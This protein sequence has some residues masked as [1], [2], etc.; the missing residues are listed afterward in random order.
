[1]NDKIVREH[2]FEHSINKVWDAI[3]KAEEISEWF[4]TADFKAE[5]GYKYTFKHEAGGV[6]TTINGEVLKVNPVNELIYTWVV[7]GTDVI[8]TVSWKLEENASGTFLILEHTGISNYPGENAVAM[9]NSFSGGWERCVNDLQA[10]LEKIN[11]G[12]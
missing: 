2:Q 3:S 5:Q 12:K 10:H 6:I 11:V 1:M 8:T 4:I 7:E 9:F